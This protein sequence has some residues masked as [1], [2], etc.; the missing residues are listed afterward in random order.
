ML[1][2]TCFKRKS[3]GFSLVELLVT[4]G[5][6]SIFLALA[7]PSFHSIRQNNQAVTVSN[8]VAGGL[9]YARNEAIKRGVSVSLCGAASDA[10]TACGASSNWSNGWIVFSD[11]D[12]DGVIDAGDE[13]LKTSPIPTLGA[14][15]TA[16]N[17]VVAF[18]ANG[19]VAS[20]SGNFTLQAAGCEGDNARTITISNSGRLSVEK[21]NCS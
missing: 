2:M 16:P 4:V 18:S 8:Y 11:V 17:N 14:T 7:I 1:A 3:R 13:I 9:S 20:G 19:F 6:A 10:Q 15:I 12:G 21:T 5:V